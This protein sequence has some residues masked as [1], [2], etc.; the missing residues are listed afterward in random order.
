MLSCPLWGE[1]SSTAEGLVRSR[2]PLPAFSSFFFLD[3]VSVFPRRFDCEFFGLCR[4]SQHISVR[5]VRLWAS[6]WKLFERE[7]T[8]NLTDCCVANAADKRYALVELF[9]ANTPAGT[10]EVAKLCNNLLL[11]ISMIGT[12]EAMNLGEKLGIGS[13]L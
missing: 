7:H 10:G 13:S 9:V 5:L 4:A 3:E 12:C 8:S 11:G 6:R 1:T 2:F